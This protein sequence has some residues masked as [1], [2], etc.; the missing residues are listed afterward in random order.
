MNWVRGLDPTQATILGIA[1]ALVTAG[2]VLAVM[3]VSSRGTFMFLDGVVHNRGW[4]WQPWKRFQRQGNSLLGFRVVLSLAGLGW[5]ALSAGLGVG[6]AWPDIQARQLGYPG[7]VGMAVGS[8]LMLIGALVTVAVNACLFDFVAPIMYMGQLSATRAFR[9]FL[10]EIFQGHKWTFSLFYGMRFLLG[11]VIA[12][13]SLATTCLS[14]CTTVIPFVG[15]VILLPFSVFSLCYPL[16]FL[17]QYGGPWKIFPELV[18]TACGY[19]LRGSLGQP[20]CPECGVPIPEG[21]GLPEPGDP[22]VGA[23]L[24]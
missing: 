1:A 18:C 19:D 7:L 24:S 22:G 17:Q 12:F 20:A 14:C 21:L 13:L 4:V 10:N 3:W 9:L 2:V 8:I 16:Y 5:M 11:I 6:I 23:G 15:T